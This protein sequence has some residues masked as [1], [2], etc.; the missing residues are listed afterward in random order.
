MRRGALAWWLSAALACG[1]PPSVEVIAAPTP[2]AAPRGA[3]PPAALA[4][5]GVAPVFDPAAELTA[6]ARPIGDC[7]TLAARAATSPP[8]A[9]LLPWICPEAQVSRG[10]LRGALLTFRELFVGG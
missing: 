2:A 7:A 10:A 1:G 9:A 5:E 8:D 3:A 6:E 4:D